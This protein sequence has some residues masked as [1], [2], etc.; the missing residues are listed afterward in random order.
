ME[1]EWV[2]RNYLQ[3]TAHQAG[4][5]VCSHRLSLNTLNS[6]FRL[7]MHFMTFYRWDGDELKDR[8]R[9]PPSPINLLFTCSR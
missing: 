6:L 9:R 7:S 5:W 8:K 3:P 1:R 4:C 2:R